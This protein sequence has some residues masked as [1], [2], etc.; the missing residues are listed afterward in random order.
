M[1]KAFAVWHRGHLARYRQ[2]Q[3]ERERA[4]KEREAARLPMR[5]R[6]LEKAR[7]ARRQPRPSQSTPFRDLDTLLEEFRNYER[8]E[9]EIANR[10]V[11]LAK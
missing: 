4:R 11:E 10:A 3:A 7:A 6:N 9:Q 5:R 2:E 1:V 8:V